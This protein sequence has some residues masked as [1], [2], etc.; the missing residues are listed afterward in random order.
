MKPIVIPRA[1]ISKP[2]ICL[3]DCNV[4]YETLITNR[5]RKGDRKSSLRSR[6]I[7]LNTNILY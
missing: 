6:C 5:K 2:S 7:F 4:S 3:E 1:I